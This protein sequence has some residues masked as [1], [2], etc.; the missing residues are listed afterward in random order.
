MLWEAVDPDQALTWRFGF[1]STATAVAWLGAALQQRYALRVVAADRLVISAQNLLAWLTTSEGHL[2][3]KCCA[4]ASA[5]QRLSQLADLLCWLAE[6]AIPVSTPLRSTLGEVQSSYDHLSLGLQRVLPGELLK[7]ERAE[8]AYAA[9]VTL[10][11]LHQALAIY[12]RAAELHTG[13]APPALARLV[14]DAVARLQGKTQAAALLS[15]LKSILVHAAARA[16][17]DPGLQLVHQDYRAANILWH[18]GRVS[19]VLDFEEVGWGYRVND[20]AWAAVHLATR[21]RDWGPLASNEQSVFL[22]GYRSIQPLAAS[23][24][25]WLP[26]LLSWHSIDLA[27]AATG[28]VT[29]APALESAVTLAG[30][31]GR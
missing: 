21:F 23:E 31:L 14:G 10:A 5:H 22:E 2:I 9:G 15:S 30:Q 16:A 24:E 4:N 26:I 29:Y 11:A 28:T 6:R 19:A 3:V 7:P 25:R 12:P 18:K 17:A 27:C 13:S 1:A 20:L 8:Q